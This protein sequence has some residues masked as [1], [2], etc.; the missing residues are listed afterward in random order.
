MMKADGPIR[1]DG[2]EVGEVTLNVLGSNSVLSAKYALCN[3]DDG[4][5]FGAGN[6]NSNWSDETLGLVKALVE[7]ME[8]DICMDVF[9]EGV[10]TASVASSSSSGSTSD[11]VPGL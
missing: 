6:R 11:G 10:T 2:V 4:A 9:T 8:R 3:T 5:R 1:I 7:S